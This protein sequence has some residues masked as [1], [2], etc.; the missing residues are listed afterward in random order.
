MVTNNGI[1]FFPSEFVTQDYFDVWYLRKE[2][3]SKLKSLPLVSGSEGEE[4]SDD[5][6]DANP[7]KL[8]FSQEISNGV[9][10]TKKKKRRKNR[11]R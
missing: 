2:P 11:I 5:D 8:L 7:N 6:T 10:F 4:C 9:N 1:N 3:K